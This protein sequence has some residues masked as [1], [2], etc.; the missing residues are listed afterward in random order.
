[1]KK[2]LLGIVLLLAS[3]SVVFA[4]KP[5]DPCDHDPLS[6]AC[7]ASGHL[8]PTSN[9][10][11]DN[12]GNQGGDNGGTNSGGQGCSANGQGNAGGNGQGLGCSNGQPVSVDEP[13]PV[14]L[15]GLGF[16]V[17]GLSLYRNKQN[18]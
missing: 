13:Q 8:N 15:L 2:V 11:T 17:I 16:S 1:M 12:P 7:L 3:V 14:L 4:A 10:P 6:T 18:S 5:P 9:N